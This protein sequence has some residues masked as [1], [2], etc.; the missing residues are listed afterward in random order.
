MPLQLR[1]NSKDWIEFVVEEMMTL[2]GP[3]L[4]GIFNGGVPA[5]THGTLSRCQ[6]TFQTVVALFFEVLQDGHDKLIVRNYGHYS[7][8]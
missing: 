2:T 1:S 3:E 7:K 4:E 8:K 6:T 5:G